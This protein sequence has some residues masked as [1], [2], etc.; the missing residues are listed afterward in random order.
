LCG[1]LRG[2]IYEGDE[3]IHF[4]CPIV[5]PTRFDINKEVVNGTLVDD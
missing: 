5:E 4:I 2:R 3:A 1:Y